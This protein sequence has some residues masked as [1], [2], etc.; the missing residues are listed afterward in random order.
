MAEAADMSLGRL[1]SLAGKWTA[2]SAFATSLLYL[3]GYL[4]LR[5]Q[6]SVYGVAT[7]LDVFDERYLFAGCRFLVYLVS[8]V[9]NVLLIA[10]LLVGIGYVP[11]KLIPASRKEWL[12]GS[13]AAWTASPA[14]LPLVGTLCGLAFIQLVL[15]QCFVFGN[16]LV[17]KE[18][19]PYGW[20]TG[21]LLT[22]NANR[23]LYFTGLVAGTLATSMLLYLACGQKAATPFSNVLVGV[24]FFLVGVEF[25]FLPVNYGILI[26]SQQLPRVSEISSDEKRPPGQESWLV[27][28]SKD[29]L[30]FFVQESPGGMRAIVTIP[31]KETKIKVVAYDRIFRV[32]FGDGPARAQQTQ[33]VVRP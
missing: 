15:K 16:L 6:L 12:A 28:E 23:S 10:F 30:T 32:L 22:G 24:L 1:G 11:Y 2:Y 20:I 13:W 14:R 19:P 21:I 8:E 5:F 17:A 31:R 26:A 7:S 33:E 4:A 27:W 9:P 29:A 3:F 18:L 25:L